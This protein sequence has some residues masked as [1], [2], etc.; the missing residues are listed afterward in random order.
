MLKLYKKENTNRLTYGLTL[1]EFRCKCSFKH[2]RVTLA[3]TRLTEAY[4]RLRFELDLPFNVLSG[5]RCSE[6]N[7]S[8]GGQSLSRH[9]TGEA[10]DIAAKNILDVYDL[11]TFLALARNAGFTFIKY[12][13]EKGFFHLDV[14]RLSE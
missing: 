11:E 7:F 9:L 6:H 5:Y 13:S 10:I 12:Y 4:H 3:D 1:E 2:C 8:V 14:R